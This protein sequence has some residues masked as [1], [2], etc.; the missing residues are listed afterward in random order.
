[1]S[2]GK[3]NIYAGN[4]GSANFFALRQNNSGP[5]QAVVTDIG[6]TTSAVLR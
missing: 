3:V 5:G 1:L 2:T 6:I 4:R